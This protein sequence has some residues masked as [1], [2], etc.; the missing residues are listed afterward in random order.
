MR[1]DV[2]LVFYL[3]DLPYEERLKELGIHS[4]YCR[5]QPGDLIETFKILNGY[6]DIDWSNLFTLNHTSHGTRGHHLKLQKH[7]CR[8][9]VRA[10]F[11]ANKIVNEWNC[12][13][14]FVGSPKI[15]I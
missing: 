8:L 12:L 9:Q 7:Q 1:S 2:K 3:A 13:L 10:D 15:W 11:F 14:Q 6:Y 5:R 4:L